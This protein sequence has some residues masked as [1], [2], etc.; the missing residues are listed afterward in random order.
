MDSGMW[1]L[2]FLLFPFIG[3]LIIIFLLAKFIESIGNKT[4]KN[5]FDSGTDRSFG[6]E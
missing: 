3:L 4:K 5:Q 6:K 1:V 2:G